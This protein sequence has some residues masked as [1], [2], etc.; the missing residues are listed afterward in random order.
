LSRPIDTVLCAVLD[1]DP[2]VPLNATVARES[3]HELAAGIDLLAKLTGAQRV[4][5]AA[6]PE[7][8]RGWFG[9]LDPL[10]RADGLRLIPLSGDYPQ[11]HPTLLLHTLLRRRLRPGRLPVEQGVLLCDAPAAV[12]VGRCAL[13]DEPMLDVPLAVRDHV[14]RRTHLL[15]VPIGASVADICRAI[16]VPAGEVMIRAGDFL[17]DQRVPA[18]AIIGGGGELSLQIATREVPENPDPCIRCGWCVE[19]CPTR[20]NPAGLLEASQRNN[21]ALAEHFGLPACIECGICTY[22]CP[23]RLPLLASIRKLRASGVEA[24]NVPFSPA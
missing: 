14:A 21:A 16:G 3:S 10:V 24:S 1:S 2:H 15:T 13:R 6:D 11:S 22:V 23:S 5:V 20:I 4:W 12:A 7:Q 18:D 19:S 17:R 8:A 9:A